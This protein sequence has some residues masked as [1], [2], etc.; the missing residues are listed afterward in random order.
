MTS[1]AAVAFSFAVAPANAQVVITDG[2]TTPVIDPA[3]GVTVAAGVTSIISDGGAGQPFNS[4]IAYENQGNDG[5]TIDNAGILINNDTNDQN[6]VVSLD[7]SEDQITIINSGTFQGINGV[8]FT[9]GD[10]TNIT[11]SGL[12]EGTGNQDEGVIYYDREVDGLLN[13]ITNSGTIRS[14]GGPTLG[15]DVLLGTDP[16]S[17]DFTDEEGIGRFT[18]INTATGV[19]ENLDASGGI[20]DSDSDAIN[21][22]GDPG[23]QNG[24]ARGCLEDS[25]T[26]VLCQAEVVIDNAGRISAAR[27]S[28]SNAAIRVEQD[29]VISG[30]ITNQAGGII[31]AAENAILIDAAHADHDLIIFN[32]GTID[33]DTSSGVFIRGAGVTVDNLAGGV[34]SGR[35]EGIK[36]ED[37]GTITV[38][39]GP[40]NETLTVT[41]L[42][43]SITNAGTI[44]GGTF[45]VDLAGSGEAFTFEQFGGGVLD[46]D[47]NGSSFTDTFNVSMGTFTLTDDI[48]NDVNVNV[49]SG[50]ELAFD[51]S[52]GVP[53][54]DGDLIVDSGGA[55]AFTLTADPA[56]FSSIVTGDV[57]LATGSFVNID[58]ASQVTAVGQTFNLIDVGGTLANGS[59]IDASNIDD[60]SFLLNFVPVADS[61]G[62]LVVEAVAATSP[63]PPPPPPVLSLI[64][65]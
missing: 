63:P 26:R 19:I 38:D 36:I 58:A 48:L 20:D 10:E 17:G 44:S 51:T 27:D 4:N 21:F 39:I 50:G 15:F 28:S 12:I 2:Q 22:N 18:I 42:N 35:D 7:N 64:H 43:N 11:N 61:S 16:S 54:I 60:T 59:T 1:A 41:P 5:T 40:S 9:E 25:G 30:S 49:L 14:I 53:T 32:A 47:F 31:S 29:V 23:T 8:I 62:N 6:A 34:I 3:G 24:Q 56:A 65:I 45:S 57:T 13:T 55:L 46:G 37:V 33:G 52:D